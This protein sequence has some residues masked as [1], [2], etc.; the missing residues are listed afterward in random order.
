MYRY[1]PNSNTIVSLP[2]IKPFKA[3]LGLLF[4]YQTNNIPIR[5]ASSHLISG[6]KYESFN[7]QDKGMNVDSVPIVV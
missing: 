7:K 1:L 4:L 5:T 6:W 2:L 3:F